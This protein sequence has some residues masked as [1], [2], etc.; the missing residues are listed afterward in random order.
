[1]PAARR[2]G[3]HLP[4]LHFLT[5]TGCDVR[6]DLLRELKRQRPKVWSYLHELH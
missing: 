6:T 3:R 5:L 4:G 2:G 1:M